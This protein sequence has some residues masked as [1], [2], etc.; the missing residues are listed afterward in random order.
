MSRSSRPK[1]VIPKGTVQELKVVHSISRRGV[2]IIKTEEVKTPKQAK[3]SA[4]QHTRTSSPV[5]RQKLD[6]CDNEPIPFLLEDPNISKDRSTLVFRLVSHKQKQYL[7]I[8]RT[9]MTT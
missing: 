3:A 9:K 6:A 2:S 1:Q 4:S 7:N 5:K 8:C